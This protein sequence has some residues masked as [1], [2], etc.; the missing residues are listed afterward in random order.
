LEDFVAADLELCPTRQRF[1]VFLTPLCLDYLSPV[2]YLRDLV[3]F[4]LAS[5]LRFF[6]LDLGP[7]LG[8]TY[9]FVDQVLVVL[10]ERDM[11][12]SLVFAPPVTAH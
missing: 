9:I 5:Y 1:Y 7:P 4:D 11:V 6:G 8:K 12:R 3:L 2:D 10:E